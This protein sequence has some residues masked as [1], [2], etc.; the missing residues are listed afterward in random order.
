MSLLLSSC[1]P[2]SVFVLSFTSV[3][4]PLVSFFHFWLAEAL[5]A[6]EL[7]APAGELA[8]PDPDAPAAEPGG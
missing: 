5:A 6:P 4:A 1:V 7:D 3:L 8:A 2:N